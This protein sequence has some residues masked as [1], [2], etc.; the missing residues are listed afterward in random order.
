MAAIPVTPVR[1]SVQQ[2]IRSFIAALP[3]LR[4]LVVELQLWDR[5]RF[6]PHGD[7]NARNGLIQSQLFASSVAYLQLM[8]SLRS[9]R[10]IMEYHCKTYSIPIDAC[11]TATLAMEIEAGNNPAAYRSVLDAMAQKHPNDY[12][13]AYARAL[14][15]E[16]EGRR[17][18]AV[19][20]YGAL[21]EGPRPGA[22]S[23]MRAGA[24]ASSAQDAERSYEKA[25]QLYPAFPLAQRALGDSLRERDPLEAATHYANALPHS[26][27]LEYGEQS[28]VIARRGL[29]EIELYHGFRIYFSQEEGRS[30]AASQL[31]GMPKEGASPRTAGIRR[32]FLGLALMRFHKDKIW[33]RAR[34]AATSVPD[35]QADEAGRRRW[36]PFAY[37]ARLLWRAVAPLRSWVIGHYRYF[38]FVL[39]GKDV[40]DVKRQIDRIQQQWMRDGFLDGDTR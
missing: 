25:V 38:Q 5:T 29:V 2:Y 32:R 23:L 24:F 26:P 39:A 40:G 8:T 6:D 30:I 10:R 9:M 33:R 31:L 19:H 35:S 22:Y 15:L 17:P 14:L 18:E 16:D 36:S 11:P 28:W 27:Q 3:R 20:Q 12:R 13:P 37:V 21:A 7:L 1:Q 34:R 4:S